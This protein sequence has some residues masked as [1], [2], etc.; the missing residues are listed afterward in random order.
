MLHLFRSSYAPRFNHVAGMSIA[1]VVLIFRL[2]AF[3]RRHLCVVW[4]GPLVR[5]SVRCRVFLLAPGH[6]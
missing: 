6:E 5:N 3:D 1:E 4:N 2:A